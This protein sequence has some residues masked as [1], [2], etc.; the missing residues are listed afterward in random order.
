MERTENNTKKYVR[1]PLAGAARRIFAKLIDLLILGIVLFCL[2]LAIFTTDPAFKWGP[3]FV[4][5]QTWRYGIFTLVVCVLFFL[6]MILL[7]YFWKKTIGMKMLRLG[8][9]NVLPL[10]NFMFNLFK[11]ELFVWELICCLNLILGI[12]LTCLNSTDA[13]LLLD[14]IMM[15]SGKNMGS[16]YYVG[17][18]FATAYLILMLVLIGIIIGV[19][20][21]N[22][23]PAFH[24][25]YSNVYVIHLVL[26]N[27]PDKQVNAKKNSSKRINYGVPGEISSSALEEID[28]L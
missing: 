6:L 8:Y 23:K 20:V 26:L 18:G 1:Y 3:D 15:S 28:E 9:F 24:D 4:V 11:H 17:V 21:R 2:G 10:S 12:T 16:Y 19:C 22:K 25:K 14:G 27:D 5:S 13:K 7:P